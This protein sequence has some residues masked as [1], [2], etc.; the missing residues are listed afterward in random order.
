MLLNDAVMTRLA[1]DLAFELQDHR[2]EDSAN[3]YADGVWAGIYYLLHAQAMTANAIDG[4]NV[5]P[6]KVRV[7]IEDQ[8]K[9]AFA[10]LFPHDYYP[11]DED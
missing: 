11:I 2:N 5:E 1:N 4:V 9:A 6:H 3:P 8:V 10:E 7:H